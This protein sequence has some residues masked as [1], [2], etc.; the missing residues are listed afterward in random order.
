MGE[1]VWLD[2]NIKTNEID[3]LPEELQITLEEADNTNPEW[4]RFSLTDVP[5]R[6]I[7]KL[8]TTQATFFGSCG[9]GVEYGMYAFFSEKGKYEEREIGYNGGYCTLVLSDVDIESAKKFALTY[10]R[11]E[12]EASLSF[13]LTA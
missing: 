10:E 9:G 8:Y 11:M 2:L 5:L 12:K 1:R 7:D 13:R 6:V 3:K 4:S